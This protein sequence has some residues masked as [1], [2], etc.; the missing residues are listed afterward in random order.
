LKKPYC[1]KMISSGLRRMSR[2]LNWGGVM[3]DPQADKPR[4]NEARDDES[5]ETRQQPI[6]TA[7]RYEIDPGQDDPSAQQKAAE[8]PERR[9]FRSKSPPHRPPKAPE[10]GHAEQN[11]RAPA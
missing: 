4:H 8:K 5:G 1:Q 3:F 6:P 2:L 7:A 10:K 11:S 9:P